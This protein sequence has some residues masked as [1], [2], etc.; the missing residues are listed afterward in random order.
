[1]AYYNSK[2]ALWEPVIEPIGKKRIFLD[3]V[4]AYLRHKNLPI[5]CFVRQEEPK[6]IPFAL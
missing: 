1:M 3:I 5:A 4:R 2:Y 6:I